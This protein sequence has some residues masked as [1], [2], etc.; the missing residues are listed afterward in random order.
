MK[1]SHV[2]THT[3]HYHL[4]VIMITSHEHAH[5]TPPLATI[6]ASATMADDEVT[7]AYESA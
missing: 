7:I 3:E 4:D 1:L 2:D 6:A 5:V